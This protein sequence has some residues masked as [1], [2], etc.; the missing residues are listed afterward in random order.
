MNFNH[1]VRYCPNCGSEETIHEIKVPV[2]YFTSSNDTYDK[3]ILREFETNLANKTTL[4][5]CASCSFIYSK[6]MLDNDQYAKLYDFL[7][8]PELSLKKNNISS[9]QEAIKSFFNKIE[10]LLNK[11]SRILDYACGWGSF[12]KIFISNGFEEAFA[13]EYSQSRREYLRQNNISILY[14]LEEL[15]QNAPY[16]FIICNQFLEH[17]LNFNETLELFQSILS[18]TGYIWIAVPNALT[19]FDFHHDD[20]FALKSIPN[21]DVNP[22]EHVNHFT[23]DTLFEILKNKGFEIF[24]INTLWRVKRLYN[25]H[26]LTSK[27]RKPVLLRKDNIHVVIQSI[28]ARILDIV[29]ENVRQQ[30][31]PSA[32]TVTES[33]GSRESANKILSIGEKSGARYLAVLNADVLLFPDAFEYMCY[34]A[35]KYAE[36]SFFCIKFPLYDKFIGRINE[37]VF[38]YNTTY[39]TKFLSFLENNENLKATFNDMVQYF[40]EKQNLLNPAPH[41]IIGK[42]SYFQYFRYLIQLYS[43]SKIT[44]EN[45]GVAYQFAV[46]MEQKKIENIDDSDFFVICETLANPHLDADNILAELGLTEKAPVDISRASSIIDGLSNNLIMRKIFTEERTMRKN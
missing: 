29:Y 38:L 24:D 2:G 46:S 22:W 35:D 8:V 41:Y 21:K 37:G 14:N 42:C 33:D 17:D 40:L 43:E 15:K 4:V 26:C 13:F 16:D 30:I 19:L 10:P 44:N 27:P 1:N 6:Y 45:N 20:T 11:K 25:T 5:K 3:N 9:K 28:G 23:P 32:I 12:L 36:D 39:I 7:I 31:E 18:E 34:E